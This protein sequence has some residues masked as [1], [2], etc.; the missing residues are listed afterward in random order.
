MTTTTDSPSA[1]RAE[2][3]RAPGWVT[4]LLVILLLA[5]LPVAVWLDLRDVSEHALQVQARDINSVITG[6]RTYYANN[7]VSRVLSVPG[8]SEVI[9]NYKDVK[10]AIPIPATLSL[11][12]GKVIGEQQ[13]NIT[14]RF[15]SD[16]PFKGRASHA[17]D[18]F[19]QKALNDLRA[20]PKQIITDTSWAG[21]TGQVRLVAP[22]M[23]GGPCVACHNTHPDSPKRDWEVGDVR[24]IQEIIVGA[25]M[26]SNI[27]VFKHLLSYFA[28]MVAVGVTF[29]FM[30]RRLTTAIGSMNAE[31]AV[32]NSGLA[33]RSRQLADTVVELQEA[34][35][36]AMEASRTKSSFLANMSHELRTPL[37]AIIGLTELMSENT[38]R[39]GTEKAAEPLRRVLRA[40][41]HLLTLING[42][43]DLSKIEA[44][45]LDL[46][47]EPVVIQPMLEEVMGL[48]KPLAEANKNQLTLAFSG[49][50][51]TTIQADGTR[52]RQILLN[53]LSNA[54][55]FTKS[56]SV[57]LKVA[58]VQ[59]SGRKWIEFAVSDTGIGMSAEQMGRL[60][61]EFT[62]ADASTTREFGGTGLGLAITRKLC[63]LM[64]G[65]VTVESK[66]GKGSTFTVRLP[67]EA[68]D[69][70]AGPVPT[71]ASASAA[72]DAG[73]GTVLVIDDDAT[74]REL[75]TTYLVQQG[76][77]VVTESTGVAG[78]KRARELHPAAIMLDIVM[79]DIDGWTVIAALKGD[80]ALSDIPVIIVSIV[81][82]ARR[83]IALGAAGY[84][85]KP[86]EKEKLLGVLSA[87]RSQGGESSVLVVEDDGEQ[88][89]I[90][91]SILAGQ[92]WTVSEAANGRLALDALGTKLPDVIL[93]DLMMPEMDGFQV[94]AELQANPA[95]RQIPVVVVTAL[96]LT[97]HD[98]E[99][100]NRGVEHIVFKNASSQ[101]ELLTYVGDLLAS[102]RNK[103]KRLQDA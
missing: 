88:R 35:D 69:A 42:I 34:R 71:D 93:L 1:T 32:A 87:F 97:Q 28:F 89:E 101:R 11:E 52:V 58:P 99:R 79:P 90:M 43:L 47:L 51:S 38:T 21:L 73:R 55:K 33:S 82:E 7:V 41:R 100:L 56:G 64:G 95:W 2:R 70:A 29:I 86:I 91:R 83:G 6:V 92:G 62:Q 76:F 59:A 16:F 67:V 27:L 30:Q 80:P 77:S 19:E 4:V 26:V 17:L 68:A 48:A 9:H 5:G 61:Q 22:V 3:P 102:A 75:M 50:G 63:Q 81:D 24:G 96:D 53:L 46:T 37:N 94:V 13:S 20:N 57:V 10:G 15:V 14:Y 45:K 85:T 44:G 36:Q 31:L 40:G 98:R 49:D 66:V 18:A 65:D 72:A 25:S 8:H 84:L 39:F 54:A 103:A 78:L 12:L 23:M 60:F 74:A